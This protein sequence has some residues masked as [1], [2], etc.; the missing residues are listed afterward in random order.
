[1]LSRQEQRVETRVL[2]IASSQDG[3]RQLAGPYVANSEKGGVFFPNL[4]VLL[5]PFIGREQEQHALCQLL[6]QSEIR[7]VTLTGTGGV[8]KTRLA[9]QIAAELREN[10]AN[11]VY[12]VPLAALQNP[13]DVLVA[14]AQSLGLW[15]VADLPLE[16]QVENSLREKHVLLLLDNFEQVIAAAPQLVRLLTS[17]SQ[18][19]LL[20]TS[21]AT[22]HLSCEHEFLLPPLLVPDLTHSSTNE[23]LARVASVRLFVERARTVQPD[24]QLTPSNTL[25]IAE[26][27]ARLDGLPLA[28]E[29]AA[30]RIK[31][32]PP[33]ALLRRLSHRLEILTAGARDLPIRQQTLRNTLQ[34]SYDLLTEEEQR[35]FRWLSIFV[36]GCTLEAA[37][38]IYPADNGYTSVVLEGVASLLDKS[39]VQ[40]KER[41]GEEPRFVM[42]ETIREFGLECLHR[43]GELEAARRAHAGYYLEM[44]EAAEPHFLGPSQLMWFDR[45]EKELD[46]L[47]AILKVD[48]GGGTEEVELALRLASALFYFWY[49]RSHLREGR[50][51]LEHH[52]ASNYTIAASIRLKA[53]VVLQAI[54]WTQNDARGLEQVAQEA[55][56]L[57]QGD[58]FNMT[59]AMNVRGVAMMLE[60][61]DYPKAQA[62]LEEVLASARVLDDR[63]LLL[64]AF[65]NLG[66]L[67]L[68]QRDASRAIACLE[69]VLALY[70][71]TGD[72]VMRAGALSLLARAELLQDNAIRARM[73]LEEGLTIFREIGNNWGAALT[74]SLLGQS[75]FQQKEMSQAMAFLTEGSQ[76][77]HEV[78]DR[79]I[80]AHACL[81]Q[82]SGATLQRDY[83]L[84]RQHYE[85]GLTIAFSIEH[86]GFIASGLKGL[87][88]VAAAQGLFTWAAVLWGNAESLHES[89]SV[90][91]PR[92]LY[93]HMV[94]TVR[95]RL[96]RSNFD[97]I[98]AEGHSMTAEQ[99]FASH[100]TVSP[101]EAETSPTISAHSASY[102]AGLTRREVE[103]LRLVTEGLTDA[104]VAER[105]VISHRTVTTHLTAIY[106]KLGI[107][108]RAAAARFA[109]EHRL[110]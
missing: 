105:L 27:C 36:G 58:Q 71:V 15:E 79:R 50:S 98:M 11:G 18:L 83:T 54:M 78:G 86:A 4:L 63:T 55:L 2:T 6:R 107:N 12:F 106:N 88:C 87:G 39:L 44:G 94:S 81:L 97:K 70:N 84:A 85:E 95:T 51:F 41:E 30:A 5:T 17:C 73:L 32:L 76:L 62:C 19:H 53:L 23:D 102:P 82:A 29:L 89:Q 67:A 99:A 24:F 3:D 28:L 47:R 37:E 48:P 110:I 59:L 40:Q 52:L 16:E 7:L 93:E 35:L 33:L 56:A 104:Q 66:R 57:A 64:K 90:A 42:L 45:L 108:S 60:R 22:L 9:L 101:G 74:L 31:L 49:G 77:A 8:G 68:F 38:A 69:E 25:T 34:W 91:I 109:T 14:I 100:L 26:I 103:V 13:E 10:F 46:N 43:H 1:M 21:R 72:K 96:G 61:R 65:L 75:A 20:V 92:D 80:I